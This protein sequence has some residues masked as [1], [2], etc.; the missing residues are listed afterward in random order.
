AET[1]IVSMRSD[2]I[3]EVKRYD[4]PEDIKDYFQENQHGAN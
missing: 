3:F 2:N 4:K 1:A